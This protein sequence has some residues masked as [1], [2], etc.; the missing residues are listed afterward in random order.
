MNKVLVTGGAG[1]IGS[2]LVFKL[3]DRGYHVGILDNLSTGHY[4]NLKGLEDKIKFFE[5]DINDFEKVNEVIGE[6]DTII[7]LAAMVSVPESVEK[8]MECY[9][10]NVLST[11]NILDQCVKNNQKFIFASSAAV[12]GEDKS[13]VK[14]ED[15]P[16]DPISPYGLSKFD[17]EKL[18]E[19]YGKQYGLQYSCFRNFNV[20]GPKQDI[21]SP[22]AA[23]IPIFIN[24]ALKGE[25]LTIFG[26]GEQTRDFIYVEDVANAYI[27]AIEGDYNNV[28]NLGC[29]RRNSIKDI[30]QIVLSEIPTTS[31]VEFKEA[32]KGDIKHSLSSYDKYNKISGWKPNVE[33][34][35]GIRRTI[36]Y[37][38][39]KNE[40]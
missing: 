26:D 20:Y 40:S 21:N 32:R 27:Q 31:K 29:N 9:R 15:I 14:I 38:R 1:F 8:P 30:A 33:L 35:D 28:F 16:A 17:V 12:Y 19:I 11:I 39:T 37:Y 36:E 22:Y 4:E 5:I 25:D 24:K 3:I 7:H 10:T 6:Y 34:L 2:N 23:V 18:C 13:E